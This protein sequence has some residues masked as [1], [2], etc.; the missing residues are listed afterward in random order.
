M[1]LLHPKKSITNYKLVNRETPELHRDIFP[2]SKV[3]RVFFD[4]VYT[5]PRA[6]DPMFITDTT[7][8]D[9]QQARTPY[10]L[11]QIEHIFELLHKLGGKSGLI[12]SSEFFMYSEKDR[13]AVEICRAKGYRYPEITGWIRANLDDLKIA[14]DMEFKEVGILT[15]VSDYHLYM[16]MGWDRKKAMDHY[17]SVIE[18]ALEYG[19]SPRCHFEDLTRS[20]VYGF[21]I[22]FAQRLMDLSEESGLP[23]KIRLCD[24]MG[25]GVPYP[26]ATLPRSVGRLVRAFT[27]DAGVPGQWLEWHG[28]NDYHKTLINGV[29][30][31]LY[32][33]SGISATLLGFGE[34]TG[35]TPVEALVID[36]IGLTGDDDAADTRVI[37]EIARY[38]EK[39]LGYRIPDNYPFVG[40]E[41]NAT[42]AGIH[43]DGL[44][45]NQEIYNVFDTELLL[46]RPVSIIITDKCGR[47]G[48]ACWINQHLNLPQERQITKKHPGVG[49]IYDRIIQAYEEGR[50]TSFS[51]KE[52]MTLVKRYLP[53]LLVS[54][55]DNLKKMANDLAGYLI[56][57]VA[58]NHHCLCTPASNESYEWLDE[59]VRE[60]PFIQ[61]LYLTD[62]QGKL[63]A[64]AIT[65]P[66][67][68]E[69]YKQLPI[70]Y[71]F[72]SREW[73][74]HPMKTGNLHV[75]DIQKSVLTEKL[76][77]SV[78]APITDDNDNI[79]GVI[80]ADI[81]LEQLLKR[82]DTL[83]DEVQGEDAE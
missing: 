55:F 5:L 18:K 74:I 42:G 50:T 47:A 71:D 65:D 58:E 10:T 64:S 60:Y 28:H 8:R 63:L 61:Y 57:K 2:Y 79:T 76:I 16:K 40:R 22:P 1:A 27:D 53:E 78:S 25:N 12:R 46:N 52:M 23:V 34:R 37:T 35:N 21:P 19:I 81:Q 80:G 56:A 59:F 45:K 48:V 15:S 70:G 20:D 67:Y 83:E 72:S 7:L 49:K 9:G 4:D 26:G 14:R 44:I 75:T 39:E 68:K 66:I 29:T 69:K 73:F 32:G 62:T 6:A 43:A 51:Q 38:F 77:F 11:K 30:A 33:C 36:Y 13:K 3:S 31:W 82:A 17:T 54:E 24:T 41:F